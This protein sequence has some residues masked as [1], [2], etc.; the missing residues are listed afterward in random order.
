MEQKPPN[1]K[2]EGQHLCVPAEMY[3]HH[4]AATLAQSSVA[5]EIPV[6]APMPAL[7]R[8]RHL[9]TVQAEEALSFAEIHKLAFI[10]ASTLPVE[11][12]RLASLPVS[13]ARQLALAIPS[14]SFVSS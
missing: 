5:G 13:L 7:L 8:T 1:R 2:R 6:F 4:R 12:G 9:R 3:V 14:V 10:E 11:F